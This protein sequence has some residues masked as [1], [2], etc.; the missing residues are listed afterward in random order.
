MFSITFLL[1]LQSY[2]VIRC[3]KFINNISPDERFTNFIIILKGFVHLK[4]Q[5]TEPT[6][7]VHSAIWTC[8][9]DMSATSLYFGFRSPPNKEYDDLIR[10]NDD[11]YGRCWSSDKCISV[12]PQYKFIF[13]TQQEYET[14]SSFMWL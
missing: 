3:K 10:L 5:I 7:N 12:D 11:L 2:R 13:H 8:T 14:A 9:P 1:S 4:N 6:L